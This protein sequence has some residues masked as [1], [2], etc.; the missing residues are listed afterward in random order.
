M[1]VKKLSETSLRYTYDN[2]NST[3]TLMFVLKNLMTPNVNQYILPH[4][5]NEAIPA[6][7][8]H[9]AFLGKYL[10]LILT[11]SL[12]HLQKISSYLNVAAWDVE[13]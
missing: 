1:L 12:E 10:K 11:A 3:H 8:N 4:T 5:Q 2:V 7:T 13:K 9:K 6:P